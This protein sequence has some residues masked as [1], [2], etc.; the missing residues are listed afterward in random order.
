MTHTD[1]ANIGLENSDIKKIS[2]IL[3]KYL[4]TEI[5]LNLKIRNY[6]W[7]VE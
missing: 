6:H 4:A 1:H 2:D 7:N 5:A 3:Q